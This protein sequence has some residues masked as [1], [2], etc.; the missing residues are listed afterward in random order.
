MCA[1]IGALFTSIGLYL[2]TL[3]VAAQKDDIDIE[4]G[5][6]KSVLERASN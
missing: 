2:I 1:L 6:L 3:C 5:N 4:W